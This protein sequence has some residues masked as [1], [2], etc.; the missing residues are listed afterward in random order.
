[1]PHL[2]ERAPSGR[3][4]CRACG[5]AVAK[6]EWRVGEAVPNLYADADGAEAMHWYHPW[7]AAYQRPEAC[8]QAL[9]AS[10]EGP[11]DRAALIT[12]AELGVAHPRVARV[13]TAGRA[14]S[15]RAACRHC[16]APIARDS[17]RLALL[18]WQDGRFAPSGF[19]HVPCAAE[20]LGTTAIVDRLRHFT[21]AL[22]DAD[23]AE[24]ATA[25]AAPPVG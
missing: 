21:P 23:V 20:Y 12:A 17:W 6:G 24:I 4:K 3:A 7:C 2:I 18:F 16:R 5:N 10:A 11:D 19:I 22:T 9:T 14:T 1:M 13:H 8:L 25:L 15:G